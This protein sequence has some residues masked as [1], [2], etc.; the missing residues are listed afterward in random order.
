MVFLSTRDMF[1]FELYLA[2]AATGKMLK[3][4]TS[5][6]RDQRFEEISYINSA[7]AWSPDGK[8]FAVAVYNEGKNA[9]AYFNMETRK[10]ERMTS[11][12]DVDAIY[13]LSWSPRRNIARLFWHKG[14]YGHL[15]RC[16]V[17]E[18]RAEIL[19]E[20]GYSNIEP[21]WSPDGA[22][23]AFVTDRGPGTNLDSLVF[24]PLRLGFLDVATRKITTAAISDRAMHTSPQFSADG[25]AS[26]ASPIP[27]VLPTFTVTN[28]RRRS[29]SR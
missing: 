13:Q 14:R 6:T 2:D 11:I 12:N 7:G 20:R 25:K 4:L 22:T 17:G 18:D 26:T 3:K 29:F 19:T 15:Y 23:I 8:Q 10:M 28:F 24:S 16:G 9:I 1:S 27:T 5:S 21:V